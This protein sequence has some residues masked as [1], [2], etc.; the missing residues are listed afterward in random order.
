MSSVINPD[1][2][3]NQMMLRIDAAESVSS[4]ELQRMAQA[5]VETDQQM[6]DARGY[7]MK[8]GYAERIVCVR[9]TPA[10]KARVEK[11]KAMRPGQYL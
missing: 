3:M 5:F 9:L 11:L 2:P 1:S 6:R 10:G 4:I 8:Y 7:L